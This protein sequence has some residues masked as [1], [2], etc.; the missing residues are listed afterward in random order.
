[1][2]TESLTL[3][4][5]LLTAPSQIILL[6]AFGISLTLALRGQESLVI[7]FE[8]LAVGYLALLFFKPFFSMLLFLS[9]EL[10]AYLSELG[11]KDGLIK[12][13]ALALVQA[14]EVIPNE[15]GAKDVLTRGA[16]LAN[17]FNQFLRSGVWGVVSSI[18]EFFFLIARYFL[19][20]TCDVFLQIVFILF[21]LSC[22]FYPIFPKIFYGLILFQVELSLWFPM[23]TIVDVSTSLVARQY[24]MVSSELGF[25]VIACELVAIILTFS[26]PILSHKFVAGSL[27]GDLIGPWSRTVALA[28]AF[29]SKGTSI[30]K[31]LKNDATTQAGGK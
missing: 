12:F 23:L 25:N 19:E 21:P 13:V 2:I 20:V 29:I 18:T 27:N 3:T 1:M 30:K 17:V 9:K 11:D 24:S 15:G 7:P 22:G 5:D 14:N 10:T 8:K 28:G 26:V 31:Y 4:K 16:N 6:G